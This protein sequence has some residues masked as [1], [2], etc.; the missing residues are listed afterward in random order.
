MLRELGHRIERL[1]LQRNQS[2]VDLAK[3]AGVGTATLQ[4]LETGKNANL[5]TVIR[6][7]RAM[8][9]LGDLDNIIPEVEVSPFEI[10]DARR[11]PRRRAS[12]SNG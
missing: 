2:L 11:T 5:Q 9:H 10:T 3:A 7:L 12:S 1:R 8:N 4:R 6:V